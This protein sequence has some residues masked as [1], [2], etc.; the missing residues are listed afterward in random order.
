MT[1]EEQKHAPPGYSIKLRGGSSEYN[2]YVHRWGRGLCG[3]FLSL[4]G[5]ALQGLA[6]SCSVTYRVEIAAT[7]KTTHKPAIS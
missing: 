6:C 5:L 4:L 1:A 2:V 3:V 7:A